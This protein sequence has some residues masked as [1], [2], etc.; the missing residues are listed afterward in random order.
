MF[1]LKYEIIQKWVENVHFCSSPFPIQEVLVAY[2]LYECVLNKTGSAA[3]QIAVTDGHYFHFQQRTWRH[4]KNGQFME[5]H[6]HI[7]NIFSAQCPSIS[8]RFD[9]CTFAGTFLLP[10][11]HRQ[12][13]C[14]S[15]IKYT[16][17]GYISR[18]YC[19]LSLSSYLPLSLLPLHWLSLILYIF[20]SPISYIFIS[21]L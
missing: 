21:L 5:Y 8:V 20:I 6:I 15:R 17:R 16:L 14:P 19:S 3:G 7:S 13:I 4:R 9:L 1:I 11:H 18:I 2:H 10:C 12:F